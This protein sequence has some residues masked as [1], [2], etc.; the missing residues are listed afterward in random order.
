MLFL[1][2]QSD[3]FILLLTL[4][5]RLQMLLSTTAIRIFIVLPFLFM[6]YQL[7]AQNCP[8]IIGYY[9][10]WQWYDRAQLVNPS[11]IA[12]S[13]YS[14][15]NYA[16]FKP[17]ASGNIT[18]TDAWADQNLLF[19]QINWSTTPIS[20]YPSTSIISNAHNAGVKVLPSIGGWTLSDNFPIIAASSVKRNL[21]AHD[22]CELIRN[23]DFDGIDIDWEYP[24]FTT[25]SGTSFDKQNFTL[26]LQQ[27]KDSLTALG[28]QNNK[29]YL[30]TTCVAASKERML[31]IEWSSIKNIVDIINV[32]SY[33]FF[34]SWDAIAN[35]NSPLYKT[36]QGDP[37]FNTDSAI[38]YLLQ[39]YQVPPYKLAAGVAFYGRSAKTTTQPALFAPINGVDNITFGEDDGTP[40]YYN[41]LKKQNLFTRQWDS[42]AKVPYQLSIGP[43]Q[44]FLSYDDEESIGI[45]ANYI[46]SNNLRGAI[47]WEITGDYLETSPGSG[48]IAGTPLIDTLRSVFC[49]GYNS[50]TTCNAPSITVVSN[51]QTSI[52]MQWNTT[53][54]ISYQLLY[55]KIADSNWTVIQ[56]NANS[57]TITGL[58]CNT[59][60][61]IKIKSI[62]V[63]D[64]SNFSSPLNF[65]TSP[66]ELICTPPNALIATATDTSMYISWNNT[67]SSMYEIHYKLPTD[68]LWN[69]SITPTI[70]IALNGLTC[71]TTY[72]VKMRSI[73]GSTPSDFTNVYTF[74]TNACMNNST[75]N[76]TWQADS[77][78]VLNDTVVYNNTIY[79]AK[80][81]TQNNNPSGNYGNCCVWD[82]VMPCGGF[83]AATCFKPTYDS[84]IA[85]HANQEVFLNGIL[86][87]AQWWTLNQNPI[88]HSGPTDVWLQVSSSS[89]NVSFTVK[90]FIQ[91]YWTSNQNMKPV[92]YNAGIENN[93]S[94]LLTDSITVELREQTIANNYPL[95]AICK[96]LIKRDGT[97]SCTFPITLIGKNAYLVIQH[98]NAIETWSANPLLITSSFT[99]GIQYDFSTAANQAF[100]GNQTEVMPGIYALFSGDIEKDASESIDLSDVSRIELDNSNFVFGYFA[101][102]INGDGNVDLEDLPLVEMNNTNFIFSTHPE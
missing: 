60:Y 20:Y 92:L 78:Y 49:N 31:D 83:T 61:E 46:K 41:I 55:K 58:L 73:C 51:N 6:E 89:C 72:Q 57:Y 102:D 38:Q 44:T 52:A 76:N 88:L 47:I 85:Y 2:K 87:K 30:L 21:F 86:Y 97:V 3:F 17:E 10:N 43:L 65:I 62:C 77:I 74:T 82:Y 63:T 22:C 66:C 29:T 69:T 53:E 96:S 100:G 48:I 13:K 35:H 90:L 68:S 75:C 8:D 67:S 71:N 64:S 91:G 94:S 99:N 56:T 84:L 33:D 23:Y 25:H 15:I 12:Y 11:T 5:I 79:R 14:I 81:W 1:L 93:P 18:S 28:I 26:L 98:R 40:L 24:G 19:G 37:F 59:M 34:G 50:G 70:S 42:L 101:T 45:K 4:K 7:S 39:Y 80:W 36:T 54:A 9:P 16:F 32:M 95:L 27:I